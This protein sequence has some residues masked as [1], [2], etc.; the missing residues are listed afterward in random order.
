MAKSLDE[1]NY[2]VRHGLSYSKFKC[3][4]SGITATKTLFVPKG[5]DAEV[6]DVVLKNNTDKPRTISTFSF[7]EFSFSHIQSDNQNHQMSL[8]SAGTSYQEGVLEYDLYYNT[9]DFEGFYYLASTFSPDSYDGQRDN[10][11]GMYRD[12]ANPIA[13]ENGK[14][15]NSAQTCYNHCGSLHKQFTIQ[16]GEE[17]R[18]AYVLGIGKGN[19]E[20]LREKYQDTANVDAAFQGIKDHWDERCNKFQVKSPNEGLDTMINTWTLYQAETCVVWSRFASF[21]EVGGR[22]GLGYRDTAQDA[23][24]VPHANPAMTRK[25]IVDLLRGQVKAGY[26]LHLFD[27]DWFDPEKADVEPSKSPTVVP[28]PSDDDKIHGIE[29]TCSDDHLWI[30][31]TIIKYVME[32]GEHEFFDE[33]IPYADGG[34]AT[35]YEHMKAALNFSAE[36]VGQTGICKGLR[37]DWNDCLNLGGGESS[38]VSFLHFW[39][40]QEFLDLAKFRNNDADVAKYTEMAANVREACETHLWDDEGGWY[41]RGLTKNG[42]KI[43]TA[44]QAEGRVHLESN[45]LA[46]LSG[47]VSQERGEKAMDAVD[48]NLFSEYGLHLNSPSFATPNDD[49]GFVTRVYQGVKEN[50]AIFSHPNP[51]AWVAEAKLGRGDRA[52]KFYDALNPYNQNDMIETRYAEPYS[53]VQFIMGKDHQDHGRANHPW[54]TGTSGWAYF[55]VTNFIL[56]VRTG[57]EGLTVD[58]CIPTDWPEFEVTRQWRGATY[59]ITVQNPN[60]VSKG[61]ASIT[62]NGESVEGAIPV[63]AEGSVNDVVVVLG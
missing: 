36:Y 22:T 8:Y 24:S 14:C 19:G 62:I 2:E 54:L 7:V 53:Y 38:M 11:L 23:I 33:V 34:E 45:T 4:Y 63:Q 16:P 5:E 35:V 46:V 26:G 39:A 28:T 29:D 42:D 17:V 30:V 60:A 48:E 59:N 31:P 25:R 52:M 61:V 55:A 58:P 43:G 37:A 40:L 50:G 41:I 13:V 27:P 20:R 18:F 15:S 21:I 32:T 56:G 51:W 1:A 12:E 10:F 44:Q 9:N 3:E 47:A 6:W 57:F 49:I